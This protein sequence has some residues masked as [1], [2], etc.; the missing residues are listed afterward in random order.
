MLLTPG[1]CSVLV[2]VLEIPVK[3]GEELILDLGHLSRI[4][5]KTE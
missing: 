5:M 3:N 4:L 2:L 1:I